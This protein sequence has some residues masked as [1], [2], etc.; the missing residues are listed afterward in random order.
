MTMQAVASLLGKG[1][2]KSGRR[3]ARLVSDDLCSRAAAREL[4]H[5]ANE[6]RFVV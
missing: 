3:D 4:E 1:P 6:R 5:C 2:V